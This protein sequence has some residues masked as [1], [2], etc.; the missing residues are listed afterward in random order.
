VSPVSSKRRPLSDTWILKFEK[1]PKNKKVI[2]LTW[3]FIANLENSVSNTQQTN[4]T[5]SDLLSTRFGSFFQG[6]L[7]NT[8]SKTELQQDNFMT[9]GLIFPSMVL[10]DDGSRVF[11]S[12]G[13]K[14]Y[15]VDRSNWLFFDREIPERTNAIYVGNF[16][17]KSLKEICRNVI[18]Y[19]G[20]WP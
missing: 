8:Y 3:E 15:L 12:G 18:V 9:W 2:K 14:K 17:C 5:T 19:F 6:M 20:F 13:T 4:T 1:S 7:K 11:I 10:S 16:G